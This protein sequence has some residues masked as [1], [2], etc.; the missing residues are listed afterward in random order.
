MKKKNVIIT[1]SI[2]AFLTLFSI[3]VF[4][5]NTDIKRAVV[6]EYN[7]HEVVPFGSDFND[8]SG[9]CLDGYTLEVLDN[10][11]LPVD[12]F[13]EKYN[14]SDKFTPDEA[15]EYFYL[16]RVSGGNIDNME[17]TE[18]GLAIYYLT[19]TGTN[20]F[21]LPDENAFEVLNSGFPG[22]AFSLRPGTT[23]EFLLAYA[24]D[25]D[26]CSNYKRLPETKP[27]LQLTEY[28]NRKMIKLK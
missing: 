10:E 4:M 17:G 1:G 26:I 9:D 25:P 21:I 6:K 22:I 18:R 28:P 12:E 13:L 11:F 16:V 8:N 14:L 24:V 15:P 27:R 7:E 19:L 2:L 3:R 20:Y 23:K 5:V